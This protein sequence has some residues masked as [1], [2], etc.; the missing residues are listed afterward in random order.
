MLILQVFTKKRVKIHPNNRIKGLYWGLVMVQFTRMSDRNTTNTASKDILARAMAEE[1]IRVE[2]RA[3]APSAYFDVKNR[4]LGLPVWK[5]MDNSVYDMLVGHEVSHALHTPADGWSEFVNKDGTR[6][7]FL[8]VVEDARIE[9]LIKDKFPGLR[10]DFAA[11]YAKLHGQDLLELANRDINIDMPLIDRLN[12]HFKIGLFGLETI[13][14]TADEQ[15]YVTRMAET[16]TFEEVMELARELYELHMSEQE[17]EEPQQPEQGGEEGSDTGM[18]GAP[19]ADGE[20]G[21]SDESSDGD[22][23]EGSTGESG[24]GDEEG[25]TGE[26]GGSSTGGEDSGESMEDDTD[27]GSSAESTEATGEGTDA[28]EDS[29][30]LNYDSYS[31]EVGDSAPAGSTQRS[32][33]KGV[34]DMRDEYAKERMYHN[35]VDPILDDIVVDWKTIEGEWDGFHNSDRAKNSQAEKAHSLSEFKKF[36]NSSKGTVMQMVQAFQMKQAADAS[37]RTDIA[38]TGVLDTVG[39]MKYRWSEDIFVKNEVHADGKSHGMVMYVDWSGSMTEILEDTVQQLLVLTELCRKAGI[40]FDVYAF[41]SNEFV[42]NPENHHPYTDEY[43]AL[44]K[45]AEGR[46]FWTGQE[47]KEDDQ[48]EYTDENKG[49]L[50]PHSFSLLHFLSSQMNARQMKTALQNLWLCAASNGRGGSYGCPMSLRLGCTPL[51][52]AIICAMTQI[53]EFQRQHG[54]QIVNCVVLSDGEGH[55]TGLRSYGGIGV[56]RDPKTGKTYECQDRDETMTF[57]D[58]LRDRTGANLIGIRLHESKTITNLRYN[59]GWHNDEKGFATAC[60]EYKKMN[61]TEIP[62]SSYDGYFLIKGNTEV[63]TDVLDDLADDASYTRLK[64]AFIRGGNNKKASRVIA[65]RIVDIIAA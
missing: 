31:N 37:K 42:A 14:F 15:Q 20:P 38:K 7:M 61:F 44:Q 54:V 43:N 22:D 9:R 33:E 49:N 10:R 63:K 26:G 58:C 18:P 13:P 16:K 52:E 2:H 39:M 8:N 27:D 19:G 51:N 40:P 11:A 41:T 34:E 17:Q 65:N 36:M 64:N 21:E 60:S 62:E 53:P 48:W 55:G 29:T 59:H 24:E 28:G 45:A 25:D 1:D 56:L 5:D 35:L 3:D 6:Q 12:L 46:K 30:D 50:H 47:K 32:F 23:G 4:V 57:L